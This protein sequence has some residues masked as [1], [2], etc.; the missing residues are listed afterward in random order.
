[1]LFCCCYGCACKLIVVLSLYIK[2]HQLT[3]ITLRCAE[4]FPGPHQCWEK[5]GLVPS[6][7]NTCAV[8]VRRKLLYL[9]LENLLCPSFFVTLNFVFNKSSS[10]HLH[11]SI[12]LEL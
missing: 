5:T 3:R 12:A 10:K 6:N 7:I 9:L 4:A 11:D 8:S 2:L 1:M